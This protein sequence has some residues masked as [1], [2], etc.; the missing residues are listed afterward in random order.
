M[1]DKLNIHNQGRDNPNFE[2][3]IKTNLQK[4]STCTRIPIEVIMAIFTSSYSASRAS[5]LL[6]QKFVDPERMNFIN[7]FTKPTREQVITW[8][9]LQGDLNIPDFFDYR[10]AYLKA[11]WIGDPMGSVDPVK[12][13]KAHVLAID[14]KL[15]TREKSTSDL[16]HGD[17]TTNVDILEKEN[18]LLLEKGL[19]LKPEEEIGTNG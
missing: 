12:D 16:G 10:T 6:M 9:V 11:I 13:V 1:G 19:I 4:T 15:G 18:E 5:M 3:Y 7:S 2:K 14:N 8:G 17:F